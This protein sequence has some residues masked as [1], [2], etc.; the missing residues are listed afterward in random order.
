KLKIENF[1]IIDKIEIDFAP[2]LTILTGETGAGKSIIIDALNLALGEKASS[3]VIRAGSDTATVE[4]TFRLDGLSSGA[5]AFLL[6]KNL[7]I[8]DGI[9]HLKREVSVNGRSRAWINGETCLL[10]V[11]KEVGNLLVD[12]HGQHDHQSLLNPETHIQFLD[13]F[14]DYD[15][16]LAEVARQFDVL[17]LLHDRQNLLEQQ[18]RLNREKREL[19]EFQLQEIQKIAPQ[20]NEYED[21]LQEKTIL[22]NAEKIQQLSAGLSTQLYDSNDSLYNQLQ[23]AL[24][25]LTSLQKI[26]GSFAEQL[27]KLEE[28]QYLFQE[29]ARQLSRFNDNL[30]F[31]PGRLETV[32][33]RLYQLQQLIKKYG[34]SLADVIAFGEKLK[35]NLNGSDD[36]VLQIANNTALIKEALGKYTV[37][38]RQL[39][40]ER[41]RYARQFKQEIE[42]V[43]GRLGINSADFIVQSGW[44][45]DPA[46]WI[47]I[48]GQNYKGTTTGID[49]VIFEIST[50]RGEPRRPLAEIVSGGEVSRIMLAIKAILAGRDQIPVLIFDEIDTGISGKI[51]RE[52]GE[53]LRE[54]AKVHQ[55]ICITH[56]P[57]IAGLAN[58]H[59]SVIK[60]AEDGRS[61][62]RIHRLNVDQRVTEIAKLIGGR[63]ISETTLNQ[64]RELME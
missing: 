61:R 51:A 48:E 36:L 43:L 31:N 44:M 11:L 15:E 17:K 22:E 2:G 29:T 32:N 8:R 47:V 62:T 23:S 35:T 55:V 39:S 42:K 6:T 59:F 7:N 37:S 10:A 53:E 25:Q 64:A 63:S 45:P 28:S 9:L 34:P 13:G 20:A 27:A 54:L 58:E 18:L 57:Q 1:A 60:V 46:G 41:V 4:C 21:L 50:N 52:V 26:T 38:A 24:K 12:L 30:Q 16:L 56:L 19:W 14:G 5:K 33:Q 40:G 49:Q 3:S